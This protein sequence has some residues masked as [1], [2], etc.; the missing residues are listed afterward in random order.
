MTIRWRN[1]SKTELPG[2]L[3]TLRIVKREGSK[4]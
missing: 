3:H 4:Y 2:E 1:V